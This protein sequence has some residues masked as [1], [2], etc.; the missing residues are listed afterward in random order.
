MEGVEKNGCHT[1]HIRLAGPAASHQL[2]LSD[3]STV[4][5]VDWTVFVMCLLYKKQLLR[6]NTAPFN[7]QRHDKTYTHSLTSTHLRAVRST[8]PSVGGEG[9]VVCSWSELMSQL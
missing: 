4:F 6:L 7:G 9:L 3:N 5:D 8:L 1:L 2:S